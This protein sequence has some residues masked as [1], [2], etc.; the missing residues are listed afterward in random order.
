MTDDVF[1]NGMKVR[2]E[3]LGNKHVDKA[4]LKKK[5]KGDGFDAQVGGF[6]REQAAKKGF[7][8]EK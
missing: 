7:R 4:E 3:V 6:I 2:R 8:Y 5:G 1:E